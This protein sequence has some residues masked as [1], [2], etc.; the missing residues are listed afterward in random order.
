MKIYN[1]AYNGLFEAKMAIGSNASKLHDNNDLTM[2]RVE[3]ES[4]SGFSVRLSDGKH[5]HNF[6]A[7]QGFELCVGGSAGRE[8]FINLMKNLIAQ[9]E[10]ERAGVEIKRESTSDSEDLAPNPLY[11]N[12]E[13]TGEDY[14][15]DHSVE[16]RMVY[17]DTELPPVQE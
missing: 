8:A 7:V 11:F 5:W 1:F 15:P 14:E 10:A 17:E 9:D 4:C 13:Y 16:R 3:V 6:G 12:L 2:I